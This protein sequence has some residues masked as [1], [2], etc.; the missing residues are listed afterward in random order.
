M[1]I[2]ADED[3]VFVRLVEDDVLALLKA[4]DTGGNQIAGPAEARRI[5][6]HLEASCELLNVVFGLLFA[7]CVDCV[8]E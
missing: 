4:A 7:P 1:E 6:Q 8:V 3:A 2:S 5:S